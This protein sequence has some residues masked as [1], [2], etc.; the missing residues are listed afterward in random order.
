MFRHV[1]LKQCTEVQ[2]I[3]F[4]DASQKGY[5]AVVYMRLYASKIGTVHLLTAKSKVAP[6][7][8]SKLD[9]SLSVPRVELCGT[10]LLAQTLHRV[11]TALSLITHISSIHAWTD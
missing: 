1:P 11:Q 10:L 2:L 4:S 3:G 7:K 5:L 6:L 9:E 8:N